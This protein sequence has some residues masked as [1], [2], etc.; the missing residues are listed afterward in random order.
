MFPGFPALY[1]TRP[2]AAVRGATK[3]PPTRITLTFPAINAAREVWFV[4]AGQDKAGAVQMALSGAGEVQVPA[5][6]ARGRQRTL[7][8]LDRAAASQLPVD[9]ARAASP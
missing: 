4:V 8:L 1:E 5:A 6:G 9:L 3:P 2:V 7:W